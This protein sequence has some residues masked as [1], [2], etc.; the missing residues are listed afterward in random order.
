M[1]VADE[2]GAAMETAGRACELLARHG[3]PHA[4][5]IG[6]G[7]REAGTP[8]ETILG[9]AKSLNVEVIVMG[10]YGHHGIREIF[11][12]T[13]REVLNASPTVLFLHH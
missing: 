9:P 13:T 5:A 1:T 8:A 10:A 2:S 7:D 11:G 6:L 4:R 12:S 3:T